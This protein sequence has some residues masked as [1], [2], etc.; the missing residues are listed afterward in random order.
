M[1]SQQQAQLIA[2]IVSLNARYNH[3]P[4]EMPPLDYF[5][6]MCKETRAHAKEEVTQG[7]TRWTAVLSMPKKELEALL[8]PAA[9]VIGAVRVAR[10]SL[11]PV[12]AQA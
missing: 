9:S 2:R 8:L 3:V 11:P 6:L 1:N 5:A 12:E 4:A 10:K 7:D